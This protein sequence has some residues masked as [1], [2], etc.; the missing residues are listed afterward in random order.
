M[1]RRWIRIDRAH[2]TFDC[3]SNEFDALLFEARTDSESSS[4]NDKVS[5]NRAL[6]YINQNDSEFQ[7]LEAIN[8]ELAELA[9]L[10]RRE[11]FIKLE[12][13]RFDNEIERTAQGHLLA[14]LH[15][16]WLRQET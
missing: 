4:I 12:R 3:S 16:A 11:R 15:A 5:A 9:S 8:A 1:D 7:L 13:E 2:R 10:Q 14:E 6:D